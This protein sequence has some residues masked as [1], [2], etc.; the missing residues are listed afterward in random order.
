MELTKE[1]LRKFCREQKLYTTPYLNDK[2]YL[3]FKG[4]ERIQN[5]EEYT[6]SWIYEFPGVRVATACTQRDSLMRAC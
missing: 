6:V 5:L 2:L 4:F 1:W 3:H